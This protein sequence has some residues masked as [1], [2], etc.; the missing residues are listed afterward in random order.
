MSTA[1]TYPM[2]SCLFCQR[3]L[4][5]N[6]LI[7]HCPVGRRLAFDQN[8]G[9]LWVVCPNCGSWNLTPL[10][11]RWEAI[12]ECEREFNNTSV[13]VS[14]ENISLAVV[15]GCLDLIRI[16]NPVRQELAVWRYA[17][18]LRGRRRR[19]LFKAG[20]RVADN[21]GWMIGA[22]GLVGAGVALL[23]G[24]PMAIGLGMMAGAGTEEIVRGVGPERIERLLGRII[25]KVRINSLDYS[26]V[27]TGHIPDLRVADLGQDWRL[28]LPH[29]VGWEGYEGPQA[30]NILGLMLPV[31]NGFGASQSQVMDAV[32]EIES[33]GDAQGYII[34]TA[35]RLQQLGLGR[36]GLREYPMPVRLALEMAAHE[37]TERQAL[38]GQLKWLE[39]RWRE[40]EEIAEIADNLFTTSAD[41]LLNATAIAAGT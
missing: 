1:D 6:D 21:Y 30:T 17:D 24:A 29:S 12:E 34:A 28:E 39:R 14:T 16:G 31:A 23:V 7:E 32:K 27:R 20:A 38:R 9:R 13:R 22:G 4:G 8:K 41:E 37:E 33:V 35:K 2:Y 15:Y 36:K 40:A 11:E 3:H 10:D 5:H 26:F 18:E 19:A 25:A